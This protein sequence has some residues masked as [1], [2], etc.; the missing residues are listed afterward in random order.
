LANAPKYAFFFLSALPAPLLTLPTKDKANIANAK[1]TFTEL[2]LIYGVFLIFG[3]TISVKDIFIVN[4]KKESK[5]VFAMSGF[6]FM[7]NIYFQMNILCQA[8]TWFNLERGRG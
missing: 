5:K 1:S 7:G 6:G 3:K 8:L 4:G 2:S